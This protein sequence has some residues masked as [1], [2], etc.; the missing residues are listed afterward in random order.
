MDRLIT[1]LKKKKA[2]YYVHV[3]TLP[4][5]KKKTLKENQ[6]NTTKL[7]VKLWHKSEVLIDESEVLMK[8]LH[9]IENISDIINRILAV[10]I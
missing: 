10:C 8:M 4:P 9:T 5:Q 2:N 3:Y 7:W 1:K 6:Q